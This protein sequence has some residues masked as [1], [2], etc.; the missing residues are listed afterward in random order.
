LLARIRSY[1]NFNLYLIAGAILI[2]SCFH[3]WQRVK[4]LDQ[5]QEVALL[6]KSN[7]QLLDDLKKVNSDLANLSMASRIKTFAK[8]SLRMIPIDP[9]NLYTL[10]PS[11]VE[12]ESPDEFASMFSAI[13][14]VTDYLPV[15]EGNNANANE[16]KIV[17]LD[18]TVS[19]GQKE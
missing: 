4:V 8:D 12:S 15:I 5:V 9:S 1:R 11:G 14:R 13:K 3:I 19:L 10:V 6:K 16:L 17:N 18:T 2:V 7:K